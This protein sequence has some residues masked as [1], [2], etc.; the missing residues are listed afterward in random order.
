MTIHAGVLI[1]YVPAGFKAHY[2]HCEPRRRDS[3]AVDDPSSQTEFS[4]RAL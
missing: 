3:G 4:V 2:R 1:Q